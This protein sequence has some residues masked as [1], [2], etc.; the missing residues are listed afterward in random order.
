MTQGTISQASWAQWFFRSGS[1][2][3]RDVRIDYFWLLGIGLLLIATGLGLRD[4]WPAD[5]PRFA[6]VVRDMVATGDWL[7]PRVGGDVYADK[8]PLYFWL[9]GVALLA[10]GSLRLAFL[11]PSLLSALACVVLLYDLGR[12]LW[13][14]ETGLAA[15]FALLLSLQFVWQSRQA[16]IDATLC[17]WCVLSLY[18]LLR[19]LLTGPAW[20]WYAIG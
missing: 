4:P 6:L 7:L 20:G 17:F 9:M 12:R 15:G 8:P 3:A 16:Q 1:N 18:G 2:T 14:R 19:H 13:N 11:I 10:T 5:E